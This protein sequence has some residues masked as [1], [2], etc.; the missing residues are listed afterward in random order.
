MELMASRVIIMMIFI[1]SM[2]ILLFVT[3]FYLCKKESKFALI[4]P[5]IVAT[6]FVFFGFYPLII[7]GIMF[8]IYFVMKHIEKE[9]KSKQ[10]EIEKMNI[11][12]LE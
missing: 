4:L 5:I 6:F 11:Q 2:P 7:S 10:C 9:N 3:E 8:G 12:D 1:I